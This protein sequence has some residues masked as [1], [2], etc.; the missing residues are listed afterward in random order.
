MWLH[1]LFWSY[2]D[3][4]EGL[5]KWSLSIKYQHTLW[6]NY[7]QI[8]PFFMT[9]GPVSIKIK[10]YSSDKAYHICRHEAHLEVR[11]IVSWGCWKSQLKYCIWRLE[12]CVR[13]KNMHFF[14]GRKKKARRCFWQCTNVVLGVTVVPISVPL[15]G[16]NV[17]ISKRG[18]TGGWENSLYSQYNQPQLWQ[19]GS[20][21]L[22]V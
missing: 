6:E 13:K 17:L 5:K 3:V 10:A 15:F 8:L 4:D 11:L 16:M 9:S 2:F 1:H 19:S 22:C 12:P 21:L 20:A 14:I 7:S 18:G